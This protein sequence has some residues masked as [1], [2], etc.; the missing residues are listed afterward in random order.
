MK[1]IRRAW[2]RQ[3][4]HGFYVESIGPHAAVRCRCG[5]L[6]PASGWWG[7]KRGYRVEIK[8]W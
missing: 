7:D 2:H 5:D 3:F 4:G 6:V 1:R 8:T